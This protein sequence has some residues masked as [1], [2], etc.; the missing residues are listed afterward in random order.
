M[1][2]TEY[3][4]LRAAK[5]YFLHQERWQQISL[6]RMPSE[7]WRKQSEI[8]NWRTLR[9]M[10]WPGCSCSMPGVCKLQENDIYWISKVTELNT[11]QKTNHYHKYRIQPCSLGLLLLVLKHS[12]LDPTFLMKTPATTYLPHLLWTSL[13]KLDWNIFKKPVFYRVSEHINT[14]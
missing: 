14:F 9:F 2:L 3:K 1:Q 10:S 11:K 8:T 13:P 6:Q 4:L 12:E 5:Y 7:R